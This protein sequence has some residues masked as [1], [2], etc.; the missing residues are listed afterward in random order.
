MAITWTRHAKA[1]RSGARIN[2]KKKKI[3]LF[4]LTRGIRPFTICLAMKKKEL[5]KTASQEGWIIISSSSA[6][7]IEFKK[8]EAPVP[9]NF[10]DQ[11]YME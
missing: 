5:W 9:R 2:A 11:L 10:R 8:I 3:Y 4:Q 7:L 6:V 1:T